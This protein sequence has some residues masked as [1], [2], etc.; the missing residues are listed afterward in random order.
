M[1]YYSTSFYLTYIRVSMYNS[2]YILFLHVSYSEPI[3]STPTSF[4]VSAHGRD[5]FD[6]YAVVNHLGMVLYCTVL[7]CSALCCTDY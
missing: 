6:L 5:L 4:T 1:L 2:Y 3:S 7:Y